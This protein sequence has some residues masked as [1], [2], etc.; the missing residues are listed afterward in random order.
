MVWPR[1]HYGS[2]HLY[3][4]SHDMLSH[5]GKAMDV[6]VDGNNYHPYSFEEIV[7]RLKDK[8]I[9]NHHPIELAECATRIKSGFIN[10]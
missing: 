2:I 7:N 3:G 8:P 5:N 9:S 10:N 4:H 1:S 6:G